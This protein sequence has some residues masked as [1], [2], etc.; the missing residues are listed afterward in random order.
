MSDRKNI[1]DKAEA[2][3]ENLWRKGDP[4][5]LETSAFEQQKYEREIQILH[6]RHYR[7]VLEIGCGAGALTR[8][9]APLSERILALDISP[10]AISRA[11]T[12]RSDLANVDFRVQN[13]MEFNLDEHAPW[14][15]I[16]MNEM[17]YYVGW[18]YSFFDVSWYASEL[19][20][21]TGERGQLLMTNTCGGVGDYLMTPAIIRTYH[22]L[23]RNVGYTASE[24][25]FHGTKS[26]VELDV[27][28]GL[29]TKEAAR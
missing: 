2:F 1:H 7:N 3:F 27:I 16:V 5:E 9:L 21:T 17:I 8:R 22:D 19:F 10:V 6:G 15:L 14:D 29:F 20:R 12:M 24:E 18:L 13:I 11:R 26:A 28:I 25:I 23:F 4:W